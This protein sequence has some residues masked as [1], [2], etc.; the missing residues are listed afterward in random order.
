MLCPP[1]SIS[2]PAST[3]RSS[4]QCVAGYY[5]D[6]GSGAESVC[7]A[8]P[9]GV[10]CL[11]GAGMI[12]SPTGTCSCASGWHANWRGNQMYCTV[13]PSFCALG[14]YVKLS[15]SGN[16]TSCVPCPV[17]TYSSSAQTVYNPNHADADQCTPCPLNFNTNGATGCSSSSVC[18]CLGV[19]S[20]AQGNQS[21][22]CGGCRFNNSW[23]D[24]LSQACVSCPSEMTATTTATQARPPNPHWQRNC[25]SSAAGNCE[26]RHELSAQDAS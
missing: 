6:L 19:A 17:N 25:R 21:A 1:N 20:R 15:A 11:P 18:V 8:L 10:T 26:S 14:S 23:Y 5:G 3:S 7:Y 12:N 13:L 16:C 24:P 22:V 2:Q 4:C 9:L